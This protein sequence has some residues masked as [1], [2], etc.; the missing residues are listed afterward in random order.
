MSIAVTTQHCKTDGW[1][2]VRYPDT[3]MK[4]GSALALYTDVSF[5]KLRLVLRLVFIRRN[6]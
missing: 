3:R 1:I 5:T 4:H 6:L 2:A